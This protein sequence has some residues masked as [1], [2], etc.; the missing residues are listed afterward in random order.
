MGMSSDKTKTLRIVSP[1][2]KTVIEK[3]LFTTVSLGNFVGF[4]SALFLG[5]EIIM[6]CRASEFAT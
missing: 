5:I 4:S 1:Q 2:Q 3:L 6:A